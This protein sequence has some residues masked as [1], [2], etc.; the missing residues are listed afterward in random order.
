MDLLAQIF[1]FNSDNLEEKGKKVSKLTFRIP[2][3]NKSFKR[4]NF[5]I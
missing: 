5:H 1:F 4:S 2:Y 3:R